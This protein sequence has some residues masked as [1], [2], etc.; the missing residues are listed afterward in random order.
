[1]EMD[2]RRLAEGAWV[3]FHDPH[4]AHTTDSSGR[5]SRLSRSSLAELDAGGRFSPR[6]RG[7]RIP[8]VSEAIQLCRSRRVP[9]FLDV[10]SPRGEGELARLVRRSGWLSRTTILAGTYP[11][12]RRW[13]RLLPGRRLF[14]VT[15]FRQPV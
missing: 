11:S 15:G 8:L 5:L 14:W 1:M 3:V 7:E 10:K 9:V 13:R 6:F 12:L 4:L 2:V